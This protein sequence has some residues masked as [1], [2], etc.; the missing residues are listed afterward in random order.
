M[1]DNGANVRNEA[2]LAGVTL[3]VLAGGRGTRMGTPK[4]L[5]RA[6]DQPLLAWLFDRWHWP[7]PTMLVTAP[8]IEHPPGCERFTRE[9][10]DPVADEGPL[11]GV[12]TA[13]EHATTG[14]VVVTTSDM[15]MLE[16]SHFVELLDELDR[17][18]SSIGLMCS[19]ESDG[20]KII[21]PFPMA[22]RRDAIE[23]I[24]AAFDAGKRSPGAL[25]GRLTVRERAKVTGLETSNEAEHE[26]EPAASL[27]RAL[28]GGTAG[29][30]C[31]IESTWP[32]SVW[33]NLNRPADLAAFQRYN[34]EGGST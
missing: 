27:T 29:G 30:L 13:L 23:S 33:T 3:A 21:E 15:P 18:A 20:R 17:R 12:L 4:A 6:G 1:A 2:R 10:V 5:L 34:A 7:G 8:G 28:P 14:R 31:V 22:L 9:C 11:R 19:R 25:S 16:T 26:I 32:G 24:G